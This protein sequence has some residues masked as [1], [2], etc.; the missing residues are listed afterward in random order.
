MT[1]P[2]DRETISCSQIATIA[3]HGQA[4]RQRHVAE[5]DDGRLVVLET[6]ANREAPLVRVGPLSLAD[7][8]ALAQQVLAG[9]PRHISHKHTPMVLAAA[10]LAIA[11]TLR[12]SYTPVD[13]GTEGSDTKCSTG[14]D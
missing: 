5:T 11:A 13:A 6:G 2:A 8:D 14:A 3:L 9:S 12:G 7:A 10:L 1:G 4:T